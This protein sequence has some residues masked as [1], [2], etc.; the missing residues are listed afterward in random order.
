MQESTVKI[1]LEK[2]VKQEITQYQLIN[3]SQ[4]IFHE[5]L[6]N[7]RYS[8]EF[9]KE[10][11]IITEIMGLEDCNHKEFEDLVYYYLDVYNGKESFK[12][13]ISVLL[14]IEHLPEEFREIVDIIEKYVYGFKISIQEKNMIK[15]FV[16]E[17][18]RMNNTIYDLVIEQLRNLFRWGFEFDDEALV[19]A[20]KSILYIQNEVD[21]KISVVKKIES[22]ITTL[23]GNKPIWISCEYKNG[24][25]GLQVVI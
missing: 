9:I 3:D 2:Y 8:I 10:Y 6:K 25:C 4:K 5:N 1:L 17:K 16:D 14:C 21:L 23:V 18:N 7:N 15:S 13:M 20:P 19:Y 11:Y 24:D 12:T 22:I